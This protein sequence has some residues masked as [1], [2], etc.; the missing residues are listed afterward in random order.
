MYSPM[1]IVKLIVKVNEIEIQPLAL[2][3]IFEL[4]QI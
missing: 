1:I 3:Y 2:D 4:T